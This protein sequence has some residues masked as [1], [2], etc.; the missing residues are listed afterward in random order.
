MVTLLVRGRRGYHSTCVKLDML[1]GISQ[2]VKETRR[3]LLRG[4]GNVSRVY[5]HVSLPCVVVYGVLSSIGC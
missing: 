5:L 3:I 1:L 4:T 2:G